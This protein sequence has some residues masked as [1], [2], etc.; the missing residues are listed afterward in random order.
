M[1]S[2][3]IIVW[4]CVMAALLLEGAMVVLY[5]ITNSRRPVGL[6]ALFEVLFAT[7]MASS[8]TLKGQRFLHQGRLILPHWCCLSSGA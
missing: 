5:I 1:T 8:P 3:P 7:G 2:S 6:I 4:R